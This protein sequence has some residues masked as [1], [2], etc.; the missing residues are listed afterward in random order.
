MDGPNLKKISCCSSGS[1]LNTLECI[2]LSLKKK[3][4]KKYKYIFL[5]KPLGDFFLKTFSSLKTGSLNL[6]GIYPLTKHGSCTLSIKIEIILKTNLCKW[7]DSTP[8]ACEEKVC[9]SN[10]NL[11][12]YCEDPYEICVAIW[13]QDNESIRISTLCHNPQRPIENL[14]VPNY[15]TSRCVMSP[16]PSEDGIIYICGCV[17]EQECN[18]KL[19]F[20]NHTNGEIQLVIPVAAI[21]LLPPLLVAVMIT[22][23]FYLCRTQKRRK[24]AKAWGGKQ[25]QPPALLEQGKAA[26]R[27]EK[28][29]V[30]MDESPAGTSTG[31]T[32]T[33]PA[34]LLPIELDEMVGK[35]QFAEVWRAKLSHSHSG[36]YET[37]AVK[38]FPCE[39]YSSWK[40][41]SQI[42]T[43]TSLRHD[44]VLQFLTAED[45]GTGPRREYWLITAYHSRG[46]LKDYLSRHV[47]SWMDLLCCNEDSQTPV[48]DSVTY[49]V[50]S[51]SHILTSTTVCSKT[52]H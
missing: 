43:D 5:H 38:I 6:A 40:N 46:N 37:V 13:R 9:Y 30:L 11:N 47:L 20:E 12:S 8:P 1:Y 17:D 33:R 48:S 23:I 15:N 4:K 41:E 35:G 10:C 18:D 7:C 19:I 31:R 36:Q 14:M 50:T 25:G 45:R 26:E 3:K 29:S 21:S 52:F 27:E 49:P 32:N 51:Q 44:S 34:E 42:F 24:R 39:E 2:Y 16:Q 28:L 22:V